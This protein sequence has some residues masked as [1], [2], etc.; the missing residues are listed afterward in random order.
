MLLPPWRK[1]LLTVP[2]MIK[3][4]PQYAISQQALEILS[5]ARDARGRNIIGG[6]SC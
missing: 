1:C 6:M 2:A 4:D 5:N 3:K